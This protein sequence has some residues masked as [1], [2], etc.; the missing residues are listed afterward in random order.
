V[1]RGDTFLLA[2]SMPAGS[3]LAGD[4]RRNLA[5]HSGQQPQAPVRA[6]YL[7]GKGTGELRERLSEMIEIPVHTFDPF[8]GSEASEL[9]TGNRGSFAGAVGL[10]HAQA[11][12]ML[13]VNFVAPRQPKPPANPHFRV[14]RA[15][16]V[17]WL[18]IFLG[19]LVIGRVVYAAKDRQDEAYR[20]EFL[21][22]NSDLAR[23]RAN[24]SKLKAIDD[25]DNVVVLDE[26][27]DLTARIS[28][29]NALRITSIQAEPLQRSPQQTA[30]ARV[31]IRG[32]LLNKS[33]PRK[34]L[35]ELVDEFQ[36]EG[37][38]TPQAALSK[39]EKDTFVLVVHVERRGPSDYQARLE[40]EKDGAKQAEEKKGKGK[41]KSKVREKGGKVNPKGTTGKGKRPG[42]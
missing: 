18:V 2:R 33:N 21:Q 42:E 13:P 37:Y 17:G 36:R 35:Y 25:W 22:A 7:A 23:A 31:T 20:S 10:L 30:T 34:P 39:V 9:P 6:V 11:A 4:I 12:G 38:Y 40:G 15:A 5:V 26:L 3:N 27:Y 29:V 14:F 41:E 19:L 24:G 28:D 32:K 16:L 8:S 1:L